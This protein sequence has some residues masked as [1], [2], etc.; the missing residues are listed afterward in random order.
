[1]VSMICLLYD[2]T[3]GQKPMSEA[4]VKRSGRLACLMF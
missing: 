2:W 3:A 4:C 1:L